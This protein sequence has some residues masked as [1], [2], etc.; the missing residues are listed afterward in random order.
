MPN[1]QARSLL[2]YRQSLL[3]PFRAVD[4]ETGLDEG[5]GETKGHLSGLCPD[6]GKR[7]LWTCARLSLVLLTI[8]LKGADDTA[9]DVLKAP[10]AD[11]SAVGFQAVDEGRLLVLR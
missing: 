5:A 2:G 8:R 3:V 6:T 11:A 1:G 7:S 9:I 10:H 4:A